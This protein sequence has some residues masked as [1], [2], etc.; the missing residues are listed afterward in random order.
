MPLS[1]RENLALPTLKKRSCCGVINR[2]QEIEETQKIFEDFNVKA[3]HCNA[4]VRI[5]SGGNQQKVVMGKFMLAA[6]SVLLYDDPTRG[7]DVGSRSEIYY[8]IRKLAAEGTAILFRYAVR[9][10]VKDCMRSVETKQVLISPV[11]ISNGLLG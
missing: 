1:I 3:P 11:S 9:Q 2:R 6:P 4:P 10:L 5:L 7:V 8:K